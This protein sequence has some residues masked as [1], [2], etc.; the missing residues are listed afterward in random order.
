MARESDNRATPEWLRPPREQAG[1]SYYVQVLRE[2]L[3]VIVAIVLTTMAAACL[4]LLTADDVYEA[5][6]TV[7][8]TPAPQDDVLLNRLGVL[9]ESSDP[10]RDIET[11]AT[12]ATNLS[13][14]ARAADELGTD[15][16]PSSLQDDVTAEPV[17]S[18][19][20]V[21][22]TAQA[23]TAGAAADLANAFGDGI[24]AER[25]AALHDEIDSLLPQL[26][27]QLA[28]GN[29][30]GISPDSTLESDIAQLEALRGAEDKTFS[31]EERATPP[32]SPASPRP[33]LTIVG[34][35]LAGL[36]LG[37]A[38]AFA[39]QSLDPRLRREEQLRSRY[40]LPIL[41]RVPKES[42]RK[43]RPL[44]PAAL[45][46]PTKEAYRTLRA[47]VTAARRNPRAPHS[48]LV[49]GSSPSEGKTTTAINLAGSLALAG[50]RVILIEADLRRPAIAKTLG[51]EVRSG[52]VSVML[53]N[54]SID[55]ALITTPAF[56]PAL[57]LLL[58]D[59]RGGWMSELFSLH[60][61]QRLLGAAKSRADYV[62]VDSPPLTT[63]VD[64]L[65]LARQVDDVIV[66]TRL[67]VTRLDKLPELAELLAS[68]GITPLGFALIGTEPTESGYYYHDESDVDRP[69]D[70]PG[71]S[72]A[73][74]SGQG[75]EAPGDGDADADRE[76]EPAR[77]SL[78]PSDPGPGTN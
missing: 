63:V 5:D 17:A 47:N 71:G 57:Q 27:R 28:S 29:N 10:T 46:L 35:L 41:A 77:W 3:W 56:G 16:S 58:A 7:L 43:S 60:A 21:Q 70:W 39:V 49:T 48:V 13:V 15:E 14:A 54:A 30:A 66:V 55:D 11:A 67:G 61:A 23:S 69:G 44:G 75:S 32:N 76:A 50:N 8:V 2:R 19:D 72:P 78:R 18:S 1:L 38:G 26:E 9:S 24:V 73:S 64:T 6:V 68:N 74:E 52:V 42:G 65:P 59:Y 34:A 31:V 62:I 4:Y 25:T 22:I 12:L 37:I 36:V 20:I 33:L 51:V 45:S 53:E 40:R